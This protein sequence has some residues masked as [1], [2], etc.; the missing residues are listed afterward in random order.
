MPLSNLGNLGKGAQN[1][2]NQ[3][4][5]QAAARVSQFPASG[6]DMI[7]GAGDLANQ[8]LGVANGL[9]GAV[10][11][12][13]DGASAF[14]FAKLLRGANLFAGAMP[15]SRSISPGTWKQSSE[16][17]DWRVRLSLPRQFQSSPVMAP[18][19]RTDNSMVF[20][21]TPQILIQHSASYSPMKPVHS[22]YPF[23]AYAN[24]Q[25]DQM[26]IVG[27]F[28]VENAIEG[29]Y[30][31]AVQHYLK[32]ITKMAYGQTSYQGS[33]PPV[34]LLNGYGDYVFKN[35]PVV[36]TVFAIDMPSDV[37]YIKVDIGENG[38]W[39]P[40]RSNIQVTVQPIYSRNAVEQFSLDKFAQGGYLNSNGIGY[41]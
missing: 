39:V 16:G 32:S 28:Y 33:P 23:Y 41:L 25:V 35:V 22:N 40:V 26:S 18:L 34:V 21:Y 30:W 5:Q 14:G 38:T 3:A 36:V 20:P 9:S 27:D 19:T 13:K 24:S 29:E 12:F 6:L 2:A 8:A 15:Q 4:A 31:I 17:N 10:N 7:N 37:D 11:A 1:L